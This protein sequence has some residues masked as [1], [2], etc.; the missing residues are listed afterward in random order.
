[1]RVLGCIIAG[2]K[3]SRMGRDKALIEWRGKA[4]ITH[5]AERLEPQVDLLVINANSEY[6][7]LGFQVISD[8]IDTRT[9]LAGLHAALQFAHDSGFDAVITAPCDS[10]LLPLDLRAR[11][12]G[13]SSAIAASAGQAH[14]LTGFWPV[15]VLAA[16]KK[17]YYRRVQDFAA[18]V[19]ARQ[20]EW[21]VE[22]HDPFVNLNTPEDLAALS[23]KP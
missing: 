13:P 2:G 19:Q 12:Q 11:L 21:Q 14:Y 6:P 23:E 3:S 16:C 8:W 18:A 9:P 17:H 20:V 15:A 22:G 1:M 4:L 10:P 5:V 7:Q